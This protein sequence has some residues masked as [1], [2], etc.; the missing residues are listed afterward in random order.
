[1]E[2][3]LNMNEFVLAYFAVA[4]IK[5]NMDDMFSLVESKPK[6]AKKPKKSK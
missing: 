1:M 2:E 4:Q 6:K 5:K 3:V